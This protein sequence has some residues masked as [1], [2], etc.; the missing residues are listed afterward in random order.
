MALS[1][2]C[3]AEERQEV[4][5][6]YYS[7]GTDYYSAGTDR[8]ACCLSVRLLVAGTVDKVPFQRKAL[9]VEG[10]PCQDRASNKDNKTASDNL[11]GQGLDTVGMGY[12]CYIAEGASGSHHGRRCLYGDSRDFHCCYYH[13][14]HV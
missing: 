11:Q 2:A 1:L 14:Y 9:V 3:L 8:W 6:D 5:T 4:G 12:T 7:A 10:I 13:Y